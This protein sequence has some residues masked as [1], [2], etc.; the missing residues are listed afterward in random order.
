MKK[1]SEQIRKLQHER[2]NALKGVQKLALFYQLSDV[3][4][5]TC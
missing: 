4:S 3:V 5:A 1:V 2:D